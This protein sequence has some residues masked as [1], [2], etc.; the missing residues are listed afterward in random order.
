MNHIQ[1]PWGDATN[2]WEADHPGWKVESGTSMDAGAPQESRDGFAVVARS[3]ET[4]EQIAGAG[5]DLHAA[6]EDL[7]RILAKRSPS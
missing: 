6:L 5:A 3:E 7:T 2:K 1:Q 4:G